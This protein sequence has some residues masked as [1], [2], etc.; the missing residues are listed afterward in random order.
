MVATVAHGLVRLWL[1]RFGPERTPKLI[2]R[3]VLD[4]YLSDCRVADPQRVLA[5][6]IPFR[7]TLYF[8]CTVCLDVDRG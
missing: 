3:L 2:S 4:F 5:S 8:G 7:E 1:A 6:A